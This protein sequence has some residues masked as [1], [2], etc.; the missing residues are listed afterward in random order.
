MDSPDQ[1]A[2]ILDQAGPA[3][4]WSLAV[5]AAG[6]PVARVDADQVLGTASMGK[7]F[8]LAEVARRLANGSLDPDQ[9]VP[10][11][12]LEPV[13]DSG[14]WQHFARV[15]LTVTAAA[16]LVASVSD[17]LATNALIDLVGLSSVQDLSVCLGMGQTMLLDRIRD[18]R[19]PA[20]PRAPSVGCADDLLQ[21]MER[22]DA[23]T[24]V[25]A[26]VS[27][28]MRSWLSLGTDLSMVAAAAGLDPL[29]HAAEAFN[30]TG[31]DE[32]VRADAGVFNV[33][34]GACAYAVIANWDPGQ[35]AVRAE[36]IRAMRS[37]GAYLLAAASIS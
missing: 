16:V 26:A 5:H 21:F 8:L 20:D 2:S 30:K 10:A 24:L 32:G 34:Q 22:V 27:R 25:D 37:V 19:G 36:V 23:G 35:P 3:V 15:P 14:L 29:A 6:R 1:L 13:A 7:V 28:Q 12:G 17:N 31:T 18:A 4:R 11:D 9:P 33:G